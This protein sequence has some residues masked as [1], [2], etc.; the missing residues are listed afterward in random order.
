MR[1]TF[2][3]RGRLFSHLAPEQQV[4]AGHPLRTI[5][6]LVR[7]VLRE[8]VDDFRTLH[9]T[10][11]RPSIP[12]KQLL[13]ALLLD[14]LY[15]VGSPR[16]LIA[17]PDYILRHRWFIGLASD[18]AVWDATTLTKNRERLQR[19]DLFNRFMKTLWHHKDVTTCCRTSICPS[20]AR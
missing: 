16:Q 3:D 14:M 20:T 7:E 19:G 5:R 17:Q 9:S 4:A 2:D 11:G 18:D 10:T 12:P 6:T 8:L 1:G 15:G 13:S